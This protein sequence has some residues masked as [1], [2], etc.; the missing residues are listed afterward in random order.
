[1][2]NPPAFFLFTFSLESLCKGGG[3]GRGWSPCL[4]LVSILVLFLRENFVAKMFRD[5]ANLANKGNDLLI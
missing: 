5:S 2:K 1:M 4:V 3:E